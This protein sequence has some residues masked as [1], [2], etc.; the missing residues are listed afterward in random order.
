MKRQQLLVGLCGLLAAAAVV[1]APKTPVV[2]PVNGQPFPVKSIKVYEGTGI[3]FVD[4]NNRTVRLK[5]EQFK[6]AY[7]PEPEQVEA[8]EKFLASKEYDKVIQ[9]AGQTLSAYGILGWGD[10][11][12]YL[13]GMAYLEKNE[14]AKAADAFAKGMRFPGSYRDNLVRGRVQAMIAQG[15][16]EEVSGDLDAMIRSSRKADAAMAF[17]ARGEI[18]AKEGKSK[19]A[20]LEY[21]KTLLLFDDESKDVVPYREEAR[22][23][24]VALMRKMG[25]PKWQLFVKPE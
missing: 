9:Y 17:N 6:A 8:L 12:A 21:L 1:S 2:M 15:K 14:P 3:E 25:D 10:K 4:A 11:I 16:A 7:V 20:V 13:E 23:Q 5:A 22:K 19:E 18:L 24:V